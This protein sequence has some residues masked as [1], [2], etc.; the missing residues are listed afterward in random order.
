MSNSQASPLNESL[1]TFDYNSLQQEIENTMNADYIDDE[2]FD[3]AFDE[4]GDLEMD[5]ES[6]SGFDREVPLAAEIEL[7]PCVIIDNENDSGKVDCCNNVNRNRS[8]HNLI[9]S[10]EIDSNAVKEVEDKI[11]RL[12]VCLRH[13]NYDQNTLHQPVKGEERVKATHSFSNGTIHNK[14]CLLCNKYKCFYTRGN[15]CKT[16]LWNVCG[17]NIQVPCRGLFNCPAISLN[18]NLTSK[19]TNTQHVRYICTD[20]FISYGG[21]LHPGKRQTSCV[22][23]NEHERDSKS[24]LELIAKWINNV[25]LSNDNDEKN[26][27]LN[28]LTKVIK[29]FKPE[30]ST[31]STETDSTSISTEFSDN[32]TTP[33]FFLL[34]VAF[35]VKKLNLNEYQE[36]NQLNPETFKNYG[37]TLAISIW[38]SRNIFQENKSSLESPESLDEF[39]ESIPENLTNFFNGLFSTLQH[40]KLEVTNLNQD[41]SINEINIASASED[42][43]LSI[44][45]PYFSMQ[46]NEAI[47]SNI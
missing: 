11:E 2:Y 34:N 20:C 30:S 25:A 38:Q 35:A 32:Q 43:V 15:A 16:H 40:K 7:T 22:D 13:L 14:R 1:F 41:V 47:M 36:I 4:H 6:E 31:V 39:H 42:Q 18:S 29:D 37:K 33:S 23:K 44:I 26:E 5:D 17:R 46:S 9:G 3:G 10:F 12:G 21:H 28:L 27:L 24:S 8:I 19:S 45:E